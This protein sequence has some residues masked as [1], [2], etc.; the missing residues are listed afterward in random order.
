MAITTEALHFAR[1][2]ATWFALGVQAVGASVDGRNT[3]LVA[4]F[5]S[6]Q[7]AVGWVKTCLKGLDERSGGELRGIVEPTLVDPY[8]RWYIGT[9][10][11]RDITRKNEPRD[12]PIDWWQAADAL[13]QATTEEA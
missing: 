11:G 4:A 3:A 8:R 13:G 6:H 5:P 2:S 7:A 12:D 1:R 10:E 9:V